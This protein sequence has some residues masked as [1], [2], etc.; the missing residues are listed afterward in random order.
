MMD[1]ILSL[2]ESKYRHW[3]FVFEYYLTAL[4]KLLRT[5]WRGMVGKNDLP[6]TPG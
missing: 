4:V 2:H 6:N 5:R 1:G 3:R